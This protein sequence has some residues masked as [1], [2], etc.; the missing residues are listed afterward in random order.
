MRPLKRSP[1]IGCSTPTSSCATQSWLQVCTLSWVCCFQPSLYTSVEKDWSI[2]VFQRSWRAV[3]TTRRL[4]TLSWTRLALTARDI[5]SD[6]P[7]FSSVLGNIWAFEILLAHSRLSQNSAAQVWFDNISA[8]WLALKKLGTSWWSSWFASCKVRF[9][10]FF[11]IIRLFQYSNLFHH[12]TIDCSHT[13]KGEVLK[14]VRGYVFGKKRDQ[15]ELIKV[16]LLFSLSSLFSLLFSLLSLRSL[17]ILL[18]PVWLTEFFYNYVF[19]FHIHCCD[20]FSS[21]YI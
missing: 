18:H 3:Q 6:T 8:L 1:H 7:L 10:A 21:L 19:H 20:L 9:F 12:L 13:C 14:R 16:G 4:C 17:F 2:L 15:R 5:D 11:F